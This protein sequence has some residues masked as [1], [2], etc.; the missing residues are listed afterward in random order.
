MVGDNVLTVRG[1]GTTESGSPFATADTTLADG[2]Y[3]A[4]LVYKHTQLIRLLF[5]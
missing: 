5:R 3:P 4:K 1:M 2:S